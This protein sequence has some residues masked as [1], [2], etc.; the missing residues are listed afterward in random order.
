MQNAAIAYEALLASSKRSMQAIQGVVCPIS[1]H[2]RLKRK[3]V[4]ESAK[5]GMS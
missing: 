2:I 5:F 1:N 4:P 3:A